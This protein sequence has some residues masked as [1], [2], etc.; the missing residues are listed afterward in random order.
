[1]RAVAEFGAAATAFCAVSSALSFSF[2]VTSMTARRLSALASF[3]A[4]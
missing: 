2:W 3:G 4:S 1:M